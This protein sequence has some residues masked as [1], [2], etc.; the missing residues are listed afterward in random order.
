MT[1][2]IKNP[3]EILQSITLREID[4]MDKLSK[5]SGLNEKEVKTLE[6]LVKI[7][8]SLSTFETPEEEKVFQRRRVVG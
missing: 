1:Q 8:K 7:Q 4:R 2:Q 3:T 5:A 6:T